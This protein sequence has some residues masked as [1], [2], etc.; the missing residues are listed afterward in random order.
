MLPV[1]G[2]MEEKTTQHLQN[3][4]YCLFTLS[5]HLWMVGSREQKGGTHCSHQLSPNI[6][7]K[8][9]IPFQYD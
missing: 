2:V 7:N 6:A 4:M 3:V 1:I 9:W 5:I 8:S